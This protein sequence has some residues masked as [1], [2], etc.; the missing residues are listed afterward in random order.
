MCCN[1]RPDCGTGGTSVGNFHMIVNDVAS[2]AVSF[3]AHRDR[4]VTGVFAEQPCPLAPVD[5]YSV[6][7]MH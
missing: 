4:V 3:P 2:N 6:P 5:L 1:V 7:R